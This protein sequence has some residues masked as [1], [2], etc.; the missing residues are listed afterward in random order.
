MLF[1][2]AGKWVLQL[3]ELTN[4]TVYNTNVGSR[5]LASFSQSKILCWDS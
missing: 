3:M 4:I 5:E 2:V 1:K